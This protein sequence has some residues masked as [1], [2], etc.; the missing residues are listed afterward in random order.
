M[1]RAINQF[2]VISTIGFI[3]SCS[4]VFTD[5]G[6][7]NFKK[8]D[9]QE[10]SPYTEV[11]IASWYGGDGDGFAGLRTA[12]GEIYDPE[13][14]TCAHKILP[15]GTYLNVT[16]LENDL[17]VI[18]RVN[19]RGPYVDGRIIDLSLRA[20][21]LLAMRGK[22][23]AKV[24]ILSTDTSGRPQAMSILDATNPFTVQLMASESKRDLEQLRRMVDRYH[25]G[26]YVEEFIDLQSK[27]IYRLRIGLFKDRESAQ[28]LAT[29]LK[30][31]LQLER[32]SPYVTRKR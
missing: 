6:S 20:A 18:V 19:D 11:G 31:I 15:L 5:N 10:L 29:N 23:T 8:T 14:M 2:F 13:Q 22:G 25:E 12:N 30:K 32:I 1:N 16:N 26:S 4:S 9:L 27:K 21:T 24:R 17:S 7:Y 3:T 28:L